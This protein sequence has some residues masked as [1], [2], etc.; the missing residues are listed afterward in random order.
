VS[1]AQVW[2]T[3]VR[4]NAGLAD[5]RGQQGSYVAAELQPD[6]ERVRNRDFLEETLP[7]SGPRTSCVCLHKTACQGH[8]LYPVPTII[9]W[10]LYETCPYRR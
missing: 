4:A 2:D 8:P 3:G 1:V 6:G 10:S 5:L 7:G 9:Q